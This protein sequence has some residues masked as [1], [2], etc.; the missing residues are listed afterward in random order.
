MTYTQEQIDGMSRFEINK[1]VVDKLGLPLHEEQRPKTG[2]ILT[3][4]YAPKCGKIING[5]SFTQLPGDY[6][7][8]A[9]EYG[10][11]IVFG[12]DDTKDTVFCKHATSSADYR[13][14][15]MTDIYPRTDTGLAVC[16][17]FLMMKVE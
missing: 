2:T 4:S 15:G 3:T 16:A 1:A 9:I 5:Y 6:M 7:P 17:A 10:I 14:F 13:L 11:D 8:V 12:N